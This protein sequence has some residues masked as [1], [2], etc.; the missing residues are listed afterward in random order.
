ME[1]HKKGGILIGPGCSNRCA[2]CISGSGQKPSEENLRKQ[3]IGI[4][5]D[6]L[7][8][9]KKGYTHLEIS[10]SDPIEY[11]K[12][13]PLL[14]YTRE[15]GFKNILLNTHA[16]GLS[17]GNF[18]EEIINAGVN[19]FRI[20]IYGSKAG[21]HDS[22]TRSKGSFARTIDGIKNIKKTNPSVRLIL[23]TLILNENKDDILNILQLSRH[24]MADSFELAVL[25]VAKGDY[26]SYV[27][28]KDLK[29][30]LSPLLDY[31]SDNGLENVHFH[32]IPH[33]VFGFYNKQVVR[34]YT[35]DLGRYNQHA[36]IV[37]SDVPNLPTYR[38]KTKLEMCRN[39]KVEKN[40]DGFLVN[41]IKKYGTGELK[42]I[43]DM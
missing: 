24:L 1:E 2:F 42:P 6:L 13:V 4:A 14:K 7:G 41:D 12:I 40:C 15:I 18:T 30:Y 8:Y 36:E 3:E 35:P 29:G 25:Y 20:P 39:C 19:S 34:S 10:G 23:H 5:K 9:R 11:S 33:C 31:T 22:V 43:K 21:I 26:S 27:P 28:Y 32:D 38:L 37:R 16:M 17:D